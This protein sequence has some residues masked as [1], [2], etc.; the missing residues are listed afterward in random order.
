MS[1]RSG[2]CDQSKQCRT[3]K[4]VSGA[5]ELAN[6]QAKGPVPQPGFFVILVHSALVMTLSVAAVANMIVAVGG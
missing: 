6:G 1:E 4:R 2:A 5:S 3:S